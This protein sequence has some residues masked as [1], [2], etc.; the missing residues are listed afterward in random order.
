MRHVSVNTKL[1]IGDAFVNQYAGHYICMTSWSSWCT[2]HWSS[3]SVVHTPS[4][5]MPSRPSGRGI[6]AAP[7][8]SAEAVKVPMCLDLRIT[9]HHGNVKGQCGKAGRR[10]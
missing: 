4:N 5:V 3:Q 7:A 1:V 6:D 10:G 2:V 9:R 8:L